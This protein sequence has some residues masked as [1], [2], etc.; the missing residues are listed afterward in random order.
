MQ[1][2]VLIEGMMCPHCEASMKKAFE[3]VDGI[4]SAAQAEAKQTRADALKDM[5]S[6]VVDLAFGISEK[7]LE[8]S[9]RD[10]DTKK[11][12]DRLFDSRIESENS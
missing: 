2:T 10:A 7:L 1:T 4:V 8:R 5:Q 9:V 11:M 6:D 3:K 12:A